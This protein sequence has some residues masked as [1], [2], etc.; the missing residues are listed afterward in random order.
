MCYSSLIVNGSPSSSDSSVSSSFT[1]DAGGS[2]LGEL[3]VNN[4]TT[5][6]MIHRHEAR[7]SE[8]H[9]TDFLFVMVHSK[10]CHCLLSHEHYKP[11]LITHIK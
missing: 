3:S 6:Q 9:T 11:N 1:P 5:S 8:Q 10:I 7:L 2:S 4:D